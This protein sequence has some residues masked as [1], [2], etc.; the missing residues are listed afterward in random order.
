MKVEMAL[1]P[2]K[3]ARIAAIQRM[4]GMIGDAPELE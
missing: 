1:L 3:C 4:M 2:L